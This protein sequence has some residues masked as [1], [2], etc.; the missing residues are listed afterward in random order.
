MTTY[1]IENNIPI[2]APRSTGIKET[3]KKLRVKQSFVISRKEIK[4]KEFS[5]PYQAAKELG[6]NPTQAIIVG[7][8]K[9]KENMK[10]KKWFTNGIEDLFIETCPEGFYSGRSKNR[11]EKCLATSQ[12]K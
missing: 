5:P 12:Q 10:N 2:P 11:K 3:L 9:M 8:I 6:N 4:S 7:R 1:K